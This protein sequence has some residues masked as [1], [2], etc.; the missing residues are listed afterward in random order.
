[1]VFK[2]LVF[3]L[4]SASVCTTPSMWIIEITAVTIAITSTAISE[5]FEFM[6][7]TRILIS[8]FFSVKFF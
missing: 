5:G 1:M 4:Y 7:E 3:N 2:L 6:A 8:G